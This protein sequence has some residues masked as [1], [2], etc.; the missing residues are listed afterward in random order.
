MNLS[1]R[2]GGQ[3][4][5]PS[6]SRPKMEVN[7][8]ADNQEVNKSMIPKTSLTI[9]HSKGV[10]T[11]SSPSQEAQIC[12]SSKAPGNSS[13]LKRIDNKHTNLRKGTYQEILARARAAQ[14][15][16]SVVGVIRHKPAEKLK[17]REKVKQNAHQSYKMRHPPLSKP[18]KQ[19]NKS[20]CAQ[21]NL[22]KDQ[23]VD[24][25]GKKRQRIDLG[26]KGTMRPSSS[27]LNHVN[28]AK[29]GTKSNTR[30]SSPTKGYQPRLHAST[31]HSKNCVSDK[32]E[33]SEIYS[34]DASSDME[35]AAFDLEEEEQQSLTVAKKE[36]EAAAAEELELKRKKTDRRKMLSQMAATVSKKR[37]L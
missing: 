8:Y 32:E 30:S 10:T 31:E 17:Q 26:Y 4:T 35:A 11:A 25:N 27:S 19:A 14:E 23:R 33:D 1:A 7:R 18:S 21:G 29:F 34:S 36:D 3:S 12:T 9:N 37:K 24:R 20:N 13:A 16:Q 15:T 6:A 28:S 5:G 22:Q 2:H